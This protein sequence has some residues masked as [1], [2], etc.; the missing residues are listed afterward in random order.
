MSRE[1]RRN[2]RASNAARAR[3]E[4]LLSRKKRRDRLVTSGA[5]AAV[6][7]GI[8]LLSIGASNWIFSATFVKSPPTATIQQNQVFVYPN[9]L[10][11]K[12]VVAGSTETLTLLVQDGTNDVTV[13][14]LLPTALGDPPHPELSPS[15]VGCWDVSSKVTGKNVMWSH[16]LQVRR[17]PHLPHLLSPK[18]GQGFVDPCPTDGPLSVDLVRSAKTLAAFDHSY[19]RIPRSRLTMNLPLGTPNTPATF[20]GK[21][22]ADYKADSVYLPADSPV[23]TG[24]MVVQKLTVVAS[25]QDCAA[26]AENAETVVVAYSCTSDTS[27]GEWA[28]SEDPTSEVELPAVNID[29]EDPNYP[30]LR[31]FFLIALGAILGFG[32][33]ALFALLLP[34]RRGHNQ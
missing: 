26:T 24:R 18:P 27:W 30:A 8:I 15:S 6:T 23:R 11:I 33:S 22:T 5:R 29:Y 28:D 14:T 34:E 10:S 31:E 17:K 12:R 16:G 7:I 1:K 2:K 9:V 25:P 21:L 19:V 32:G 20:V 3:R 13:G 4:E